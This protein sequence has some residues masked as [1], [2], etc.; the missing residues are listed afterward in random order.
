MKPKIITL[1]GSTKYKNAFEIAMAKE[2]L[3]GNIVISV[4]LFGHQIGLDMSGPTKRMLDQLHF[5][6]IDL[7]DEIFVVNPGGYIGLSTCAEIM[8]AYAHGKSIR[9]LQPTNIIA[10]LEGC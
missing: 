4:G 7:S 5:R 9:F 6:K 3:A 2:T 10:N 8:Y 1:C